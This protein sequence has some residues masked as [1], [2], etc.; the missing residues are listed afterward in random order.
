MGLGNVLQW[1]ATDKVPSLRWLLEMRFVCYYLSV[2]VMNLYLNLF[3]RMFYIGVVKSISLTHT[4]NM[5]VHIPTAQT[6]SGEERSGEM[7]H[8]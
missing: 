6:G 2:S 3:H 8:K 5:H 7:C 4:V 1:N